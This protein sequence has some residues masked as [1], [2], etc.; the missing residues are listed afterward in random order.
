MTDI[1]VPRIA[2]S[3]HY[4]YKDTV[5]LDDLTQEGWVFVY[6]HPKLVAKH[7]GDM[8]GLERVIRS[9]LLAVAQKENALKRGFHIDDVVYYTPRVIAEVLP[10][11]MDI[12][13]ALAP[14]ASAPDDGAGRVHNPHGQGDFV[15]T[16]IDVR[17]AW[18]VTAFRQDEA[19]LIHARYV[20]DL[21]YHEIAASY[22]HDVEE[23]KR[24]IAIG[25]RRMTNVLGGLRGKGCPPTCE[26][27][28]RQLAGADDE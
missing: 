4:H 27:C 25:L 10:L 18:I 1:D 22:G 15:A 17:N 13:E 11:C 6:S 2:E 19:Q 24:R 28:V 26:D 8:T 7:E 5:E 16:L 14:K 23:V 3:V 9:H 20:E 12:E 21:N